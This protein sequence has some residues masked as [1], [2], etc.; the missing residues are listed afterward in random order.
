MCANFAQRFKAE[1]LEAMLGRQGSFPV[2]LKSYERGERNVYPQKGAWVVHPDGRITDRLWGMLPRGARDNSVALK[3]TTSNA[4][5]ETV[6]QSRIYKPAWNDGNRCVIPVTTFTEWRGPKG[7]K[8]KLFI[9]GKGQEITMIAGLYDSTENDDEGF[10]TFTMLTCE[11]NE[12]MR[13]FHH[14]MPVILDDWRGWLNPDLT[15][16]EAKDFCIPYAGE[17]EF[18]NV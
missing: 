3:Y 8:E 11:P 10:K 12:F 15:P 6:D 2:D 7:S 18:L 16:D 4:K 5:S 9:R 14:R 17:L 13:A 1:Q